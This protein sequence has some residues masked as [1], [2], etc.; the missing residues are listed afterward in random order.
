MS[1]RL[2]GSPSAALAIMTGACVGASLEH[3]APFPRGREVP[4]P[5]PGQLDVADDARQRATVG[6][7]VVRPRAEAQAMRPQPSGASSV[8][9][10]AVPG[11]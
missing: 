3:R 2:S 8:S 11:R 4:L 10:A 1:F 9:G 7:R 6:A 5:R